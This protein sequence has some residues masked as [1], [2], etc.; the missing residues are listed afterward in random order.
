MAV[1]FLRG[2][3]EHRKDP[4]GLSFSLFFTLP[5][6]R[7]FR[8]RRR[9]GGAAGQAPTPCAPVSMTPPCATPADRRCRRHRCLRWGRAGGG[10]QQRTGRTTTRTSP[11][12]PSL[13]SLSLLATP[14]P[15]SPRD[16]PPLG[17]NAGVDEAV[18]NE[19]EGFC[20]KKEVSILFFDSYYLHFFLLLR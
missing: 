20:E 8:R 14:P 10:G 3:T 18:Q 4:R 6:H 15:P 1:Q 16:H 9:P 12:S 17:G 13:P 5:H 2:S 19:T 7:R 11:S